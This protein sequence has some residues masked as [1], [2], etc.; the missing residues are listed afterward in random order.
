[1]GGRVIFETPWVGLAVGL[2]GLGL[3]VW[4][5]AGLARR[6]LRRGRVG[7]LAGLRAVAVLVI[8]GLLA[9]PV[10]VVPRPD[11]A[12]RRDVVLLVDRSASMALADTESGAR[13]A[14]ALVFARDVVGPAVQRAGFRVRPMVFD[15]TAEGV[16]AAELAV[17][18][19]E[20]VGT[21]LGVAFSAALAATA[22]EPAAI[23]VLTDGAANEIESNGAAV[24]ALLATRT[25][26]IAVGVGSD[27][28]VET[29]D[30]AG[31]DAPE[32][33]PPNAT[34][35]IGARLEANLAGPLGAFDLILLRDGKFH[36]RRRVGGVT[37]SR[38]W[39][40]SFEL[41]E[42]EEGRHEYRV[43]IETPAAERGIVLIESEAKV[44]VRVSR[45]R[46]LRVL[47]MQGALTWDFKF[48]G[49]ALRGDP[50]VRVTGLSRTS[51]RSVFR[52]NLEEPGELLDG[53]PDDVADLAAFSVVVLSSLRPSELTPAQQEA[54]ASFCA[55]YGGGVLLIGGRNTF[56][57]SWRGSRLEQMLPV[58]FEDDRGVR[59]LDPP[60]QMRLT[61]EALADPVFEIGEAGE[62]A[63][64]WRKLPPFDDYGRVVEAK[65]GATVWA[66]H[67]E[68]VGPD[69][70]PRVLMAEQ[71]YGSGTAV[72]I[73]L[74][75]LWKWRLAKDADQ[76]HFDR[77]WQQLVRRLAEA[78][79]Q[80]VRIE[81][82]DQELGP[83]REIR[84]ILNRREAADDAVAETETDEQGPRAAE[85]LRFRVTTDLGDTVA[86]EN[87]ELG[88]GQRAE[89]GF[90]PDKA[91]IYTI[92]VIGEGDVALATRTLE[93]REPNV[94]MARPGRDMET[95]RQW[96]AMSAGTAW[97]VEEAR[98]QVDEF[99]AG[100]KERI[101]EASRTRLQREP[102]GPGLW[103][104][105][106]V[107]LPLGAGWVLRKRWMLR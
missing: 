48:I 51:E 61:A 31:L 35:R 68:D 30:L 84:L 69:G 88:G 75:N 73:A 18:K 15:S 99:A 79:R 40:E 91:G 104:M 28:G 72:V 54:I 59:G 19:A 14:D 10:I 62:T 92:D 95:L 16:D 55:D 38:Y 4:G 81:V 89:V 70:Q 17:A 8:A 34:F 97:T 9:R 44:A 74:Q 82:A 80:A 21:D 53:F 20:G 23:V 66:V 43:R 25:P 12:A 32:A 27:R 24:A 85:V 98:G 22:R 29:L 64:A 102:L 33:V 56:D 1:M 67:S 107:V 42:A 52:Q 87:I 58:R 36:D 26:V 93:I 76:G 90:T 37:G 11:E 65:A 47:Y 60:F 41:S 86:S 105:A 71:P 96:S 106:L 77:F 101:E 7:V 63:D 50:T 94:E 83:G 49:L 2:I 57:A 13:L 100:L 3:V 6:G 46:E 39:S 103:A 45:E 5:S 78:G